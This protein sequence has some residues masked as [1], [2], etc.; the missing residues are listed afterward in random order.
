M[1]KIHRTKSLFNTSTL[2]PENTEQKRLRIPHCLLLPKRGDNPGL[3]RYENW[4]F[5][6]VPSAALSK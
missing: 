3:S 6:P 4:I 5:W 1:N 2:V